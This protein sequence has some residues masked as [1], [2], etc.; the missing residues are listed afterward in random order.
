MALRPPTSTLDLAVTDRLRAAAP[1]IA[2]RVR[3][4]SAEPQ[5]VTSA[6][7]AYNQDMAQ[8]LTQG[9]S[10]LGEFDLAVRNAHHPMTDFV[11]QK[12]SRD[13][14][15]SPV[16]LATGTMQEP[17]YVG[18][19]LEAQ[20]VAGLRNR[21]ENLSDLMRRM[22]L[23][24]HI[25]GEFNVSF[26]SDPTLPLNL[27]FNLHPTTA[28]A[29]GANPLTNRKSVR[30]NLDRNGL[31][32]TW[33]D[34]E[35]DQNG[36][37]TSA[38]RRLW[39]PSGMWGRES[40]SPIRTMAPYYELFW[41]ILLSDQATAENMAVN[42]GLLWFYSDSIFGGGASGTDWAPDLDEPLDGDG[43]EGI[44][45][46]GDLLQRA[47]KWL[48][49]SVPDISGSMLSD[50]EGYQKLYVDTTSAIWRDPKI[51]LRRTP[52]PVAGEKEPKWIEVGRKFD[53]ATQSKLA[54]NEQAI[55]RGLQV[56][57]RW[58]L[59]Y[60]P[61]APAESSTGT[62]TRSAEYKA[63]LRN[64]A[65]EIMQS[66][67][68]GVLRDVLRA[69]NVADGDKYFLHV[70]LSHTGASEDQVAVAAWAHEHLGVQ[71]DWVAK[72]MGVPMGSLLQGAEYDKFV[73][74]STTK[75]ATTV[76]SDT[77]G[78]RPKFGR[79]GASTALPSGVKELGMSSEPTPAEVV[80]WFERR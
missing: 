37:E 53:T 31:V 66:F 24:W 33:F 7:Q 41:S 38:L 18:G 47:A 51:A 49:Q 29:P 13:F 20:I 79:L 55:A 12:Q 3:E 15:Q 43:L 68:D 4:R 57:A 1:V 39:T 67:S 23:M 27:A 78:E 73:A 10:G 6:A 40:S 69:N 72:I 34:I 2:E 26:V 50:A 5:R 21:T 17:L 28:C 25:Q 76:P 35:L 61:N 48:G 58:A 22:W 71:R 62:L 52:L 46:G 60:L 70:D 9:Y 59:D 36:Y 75:P 54:A 65:N 44:M 80:A 63:S 30:V 77:P 64:G 14:A 8:R 16:R 19:D 45:D 56:P 42:N 74:N 32:H 11:L